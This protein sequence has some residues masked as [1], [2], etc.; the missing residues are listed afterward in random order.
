MKNQI[1][2]VLL[3]TAMSGLF[4]WMG[5]AMGGS[6]GL[7]T[8]L[9]FSLV[10]NLG[11]Y[12]FS[13]K[14]VLAM[15][16]ARPVGPGHPSGVY[17]MVEELANSARM[18]MPKVYTVPTRVPNA[19][20]TGRDPRHAVVAATEGILEI[21]EPRELRAVLAHE[22]SHVKNRDILVSSIVAAL[23]SAIMYVAHMFRWFGLLGG[24]SSNDGDRRGA[25]PIVFLAVILLAPLA[26]TLIQ[27]A[28]SR[29]REFMADESGA[30]VSGD[31][32]ALASA[33]QKISDPVWSRRTAL[34]PEVQ[35]AFSHLYIVNQLSGESLMHL[36][37]THPPV[38]ERV[39]RLLSMR[40]A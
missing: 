40:R 9:I 35:P 21:L 13:D 29:T 4:L 28:V 30:E 20:A 22:L 19:F 16:R 25:N 17:E 12:W 1:K 31:P 3:L 34:S 32:E 6:G 18:P 2:T 33:L 8:A 36:F 15:H 26:A 24:Y 37:S 39:R 23:A 11:A 27:L 38:K 5:Y 14:M 7:T 10:L